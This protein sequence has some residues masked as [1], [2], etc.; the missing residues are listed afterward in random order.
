MAQNLARPP[1]IE[2]LVELKWDLVAQKTGESIDPAYPL[3]VG[4]LFERLRSIYPSVERLPASDV[5][6]ALTPHTPKV[7]L[8]HAVG[9]WPLV[10]L[11]PGI[12]SINVTAGY[13][14]TDFSARCIAFFEAL[15][16]A[17]VSVVGKEPRFGQILIRYINAL[18]ADP[19]R[20]HVISYLNSKL[21]TAITFP[22]GIAGDSS[23]VDRPARLSLNISYPVVRPGS[24]V[25]VLKMGSGFS[26]GKPALILDMSVETAKA[27]EVP[28][29]RASFAAWLDSAHELI[30]RWFFTLIAGELE[31]SFR[32]EVDAA[33]NA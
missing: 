5:P 15:S 16:S 26:A 3:L 24:G 33:Q 9:E 11:G 29:D 12:A 4:A 20:E 32:G 13:T 25:A 18:P 7:R 8:R 1:L 17:H 22:P 10:Q 2:A 19:R 23:V 27:N 14:W 31:A 21:H 28:G 6:D 30:E